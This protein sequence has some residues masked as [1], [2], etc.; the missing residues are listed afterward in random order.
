M[1]EPAMSRLIDRP[2]A[3]IPVRVVVDRS[4]M[5]D[6]L[7]VAMQ[8]EADIGMTD[9]LRGLMDLYQDVGSGD[10]VSLTVAEWRALGGGE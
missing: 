1:S 7:D 8:H 2:G 4:V 6:L 9:R 10:M 3:Q 5:L